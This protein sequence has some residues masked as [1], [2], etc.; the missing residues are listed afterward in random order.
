LPKPFSPKDF[1]EK[2]EMYINETGIPGGTDAGK[3]AQRIILIEDLD[4]KDDK[5]N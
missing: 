1:Y 4:G 2:I 3:I 5:R